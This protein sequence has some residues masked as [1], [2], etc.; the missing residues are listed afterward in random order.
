MT[1]DGLRKFEEMFDLV[2]SRDVDDTRA[3]EYANSKDSEESFLKLA[4]EISN[5]IEDFTE[6]GVAL[7]I[8]NPHDIV[9]EIMVESENYKEIIIEKSIPE[10]N[11]ASEPES[12]FEIEPTL[13]L[14]VNT[15]INCDDLDT[16]PEIELKKEFKDEVEKNVSEI[17]EKPIFDEVGIENY[18]M[19]DGDEV[20]WSLKSPSEMYET[21]YQKKKVV[22]DS[23]LIGCQV[24]FSLWTK[25]LEDA[26]VNVITEVFDQQ[27]IIKQMEAVQQFR[28]R[29][30]YIGVKVN[31]QYFLF[32][33]FLPLLRGYLARIQ[34]LKPVLK[35]DG[36]ILEHMG[37][38][39]M[40][41]EKLRALHK[42]VADTEKNLAAAYEMLSRKVT[43][44]MELPPVERYDRPDRQDQ[45]SKFRY[46][47]K[48]K[49]PSEELSDFDNLPR[50]AKAGP[51]EKKSGACK[52]DSL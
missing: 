11:L 14:R 22:L 1:E 12:I 5:D 37:D 52:W 20:K 31:N 23:C 8:E 6:T 2:S 49:K 15:K 21:F 10:I 46:E 40:Y 17:L 29:V 39:E 48:V 7:E 25:E 32:D 19:M 18:S 38:V 28:N 33:R 9:K 4:K 16:L 24:K 41:F 51:E 13:E 44:C 50:N 42:S 3:E 47:E 30:K 43:I 35:Q 26:Q 27:I 34:Y 45:I 36:L